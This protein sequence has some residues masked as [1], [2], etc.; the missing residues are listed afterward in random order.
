MFQM[1]FLPTNFLRFKLSIAVETSHQQHNSSRL[2]EAREMDCEKA[3]K[4]AC[5]RRQQACHIVVLRSL[6]AATMSSG[7]FSGSPLLINRYSTQPRTLL[8]MS[9]RTRIRLGLL[10]A[11]YALDEQ[12]SG[13]TPELSR[14]LSGAITLNTLFRQSALDEDL[15]NAAL[16]LERAVR[17]DEIYL[18]AE[19]RARAAALAEKLRLLAGFYVIP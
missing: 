17:Q 13:R 7:S 11:A 16:S 5:D 15:Q 14:L 1:L 6:G 4:S 3:L 18:D 19:G 12:A 10:D 9:N 2:C 8:L